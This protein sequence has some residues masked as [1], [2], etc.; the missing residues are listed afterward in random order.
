M[1]Y[2]FHVN[3]RV[4]SGEAAKFTVT[5]WYLDDNGGKMPKVVYDVEANT[6]LPKFHVH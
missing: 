2:K 6:V 3:A 1:K 4:S 5:Y